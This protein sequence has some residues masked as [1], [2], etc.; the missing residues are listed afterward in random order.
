MGSGFGLEGEAANTASLQEELNRRVLQRKESGVY[1]PEV[2]AMLAERLPDEEDAGSLPPVEALD[3][4]VERARSAWEVTAAYPVGTDR[5][6]LKPLIIIF[7]RFLRLFARVAVGPIQRQQTAFN[8]HVVSAL[9]ALRREAFEERSRALAAEADLCSLADALTGAEY[10]RVFTGP[11]S[12]ALDPAQ[13]LVVLG[14]CPG[15]LLEGLRSEGFETLSVSRGTPWDRR[16]PTGRGTV[17]SG[18]LS[19]IDRAEEE[20]LPSVL[21]C[22]LSFLLEPGRML[23]LVRSAYLALRPGG[24]LAVA[25]HGE[26]R[27]GPAPSWSS[28]ILTERALETAGFVDVTTVETEGRSGSFLTVGRKA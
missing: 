27:A 21:L 23:D 15:T 26:L 17:H 10:G 12:G 3:Y 18:P 16:P 25:V 22:D 2:E 6:R 24:R 8:R 11:L 9:E 28:P 1:S 5:S 14:P 13:P 20:S 19:F 4:S 7:K